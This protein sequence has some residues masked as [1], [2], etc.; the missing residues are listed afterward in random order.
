MTNVGAVGCMHCMARTRK[1]RDIF[2]MVK[3]RT[4]IDCL[5]RDVK[6]GE[7]GIWALNRQF[8]FHYHDPERQAEAGE[9]TRAE[10]TAKN[11]PAPGKRNAAGMLPQRP[12]AN[13]V[14]IRESSKAPLL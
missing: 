5:K 8:I 14:E 7:S 9:R 10:Q 1:V 2:N 3:H 11:A 13:S 4:E 12:D 6:C